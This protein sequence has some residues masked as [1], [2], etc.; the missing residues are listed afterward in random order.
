MS[1][2][3][4]ILRILCRALAH[5]HA[6]GQSHD[7]E[8]TLWLL[9]I[10]FIILTLLRFA[11]TAVFRPLYILVKGDINMRET[12]F[13]TVAG[14]RGS[15]SLIMGSA[16]VTQQFNKVAGTEETFSVSLPGLPPGPLVCIACMPRRCD[17]R[18]FLSSQSQWCACNGVVPHDALPQRIVSRT[19]SSGSHIATNLQQVGIMTTLTG[20]CTLFFRRAELRGHC[21]TKPWI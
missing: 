17:V 5:L 19:K 2:T 18:A 14:L 4:C 20:A 15:A 13:V 12:L 8:T 7:L 3:A 11:L 1:L 9:P 16:V 10:I 21:Q 6:K